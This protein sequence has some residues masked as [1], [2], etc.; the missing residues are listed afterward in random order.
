MRVGGIAAAASLA[1]AASSGAA[2]ATS[3]FVGDGAGRIMRIEPDGSTSILANVGGPVGG[4]KRS[5]DGTIFVCRGLPP[6][7]V[8]AVSTT[9]NV[10]PI[11]TV[12]A[13]PVG[14]CGDLELSPSGRIFVLLNRDPSTTEIW[15]AFRD[16]SSASRLVSLGP[17]AVDGN[18]LHFALDAHGTFLLATQ[19]QTRG[20]VLRATTGGDVDEV[21]ADPSRPPFVDIAVGSGDEVLLLGQELSGPNANNRSISRLAGGTLTQLVGPDG[22]GE[23]AGRLTQGD[24]GEFFVTAGGFGTSIA[25]VQRIVP[26]VGTTTLASFD[27]QESLSAIDDDHL[28]PAA[29]PP[30]AIPVLASPL[31]FGSLLLTALLAAS[32]AFRIRRPGGRSVAAR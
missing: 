28:D 18:A 7:T 32:I 16:G 23:L 12:D 5:R 8:F 20:R 13:A 19:E 17:P 3:V 4:L 1:I 14:T 11:A 6:F 29:S 27:V 2:R 26:G 15:E 10:T 9:G 22:V 25:L 30:S 21:F 31:A 24:P